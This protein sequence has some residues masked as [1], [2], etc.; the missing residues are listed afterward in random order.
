MRGGRFTSIDDILFLMKNNKVQHFIHI[1]VLKKLN[2]I[3]EI[4]INYNY[5]RTLVFIQKR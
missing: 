2:N 1:K 5:R 4:S 3:T